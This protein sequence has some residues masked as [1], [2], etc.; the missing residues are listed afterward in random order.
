METPGYLDRSSRPRNFGAR[1]Y[2]AHASS[3]IRSGG[4]VHGYVSSSRRSNEHYLGYMLFLPLP[5]VVSFNAQGTCLIEY[6]RISNGMRLI[7]NAGTGWLGPLEGV[8]VTPAAS[9]LSNNAC[10]VNIAGVV[11]TLS[12]TDMIISVPV[13][14][15]AGGVTAVMGTFIQEQDVN[16]KWTD[17]RAI[18]E[19]DSP[20][21]RLQTRRVCQRRNPSFGFWQFAYGY[22]NRGTYQRRQQSWG[23]RI[24]V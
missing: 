3:R 5:N 4:N 11:P 13:T 12:G 6:N 9:P 21:R 2:L 23:K 19:L 18:R 10:T 15:N 7:D 22:G 17:F 24:F 8:P 16:G 1:R 20:G 14:F